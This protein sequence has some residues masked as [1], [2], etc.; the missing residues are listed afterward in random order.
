[1]AFWCRPFA[2]EDTQA[3]LA[4]EAALAQISQL[5]ALRV[6]LPDITGLRKGIPE[7]DIRIGLASGDAVVGSIGSDYAKNYTVMGDT[8]NLG[9]RLESANKHYGTRI[10]LCERTRAMIGGGFE[11]REIDFITVSGKSE[12]IRI[13]EPMAPAGA[14]SAEAQAAR[15]AFEAGLAAY[16]ARDWD[17]AESSF[18]ACLAKLP[19]D[20]PAQAFLQR[21]ERL[22]VHPI[23]DDWDGVW[24]LHDK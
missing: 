23:G 7:I 22:R 20:G 3:G 13:F 9:S 2:A 5:E 16:R 15:D 6:R 10:L 8:V 14:L 11:L 4:C 19:D 21:V 24:H 12:P 18:T 17:G 1:M